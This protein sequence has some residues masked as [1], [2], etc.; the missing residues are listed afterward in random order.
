MKN[1][2]FGDV[3]DY[4]KYGLLRMLANDGQFK[5]GVCWMLTTDDGRSDGNFTTFLNKPQAWHKYDPPLFDL[6]HKWVISDRSRNVT[7]AQNANLLPRAEFYSE[8][9][10]DLR[11][12]RAKY[13]KEM[14]EK[15]SA[16]KLIFF[17]PDNGVEIKSVAKGRR[18]SSKY[19]Y[20][21]ELDETYQA[22]HSILLYQHFRREERTSFIGHAIM[23]FQA[24]LKPYKIYWFRTSQVVYFLCAQE[25]HADTLA[26]RVTALT[27]QWGG[28]IQVG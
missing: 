20:W 3:N 17:D 5:I 1:Q 7:L 8:F 2:Y 22:G 19:I 9:L 23:E 14:N 24:R 18:N 21:D 16:C 6:L 15:F 11:D 26:V 13:F 27:E 12:Q 25:K 10:T 28:K 4:Q